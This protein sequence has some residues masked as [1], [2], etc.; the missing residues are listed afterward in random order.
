VSLACRPAGKLAAHAR[1]PDRLIALVAG[2]RPGAKRARPR[3]F[4]KGAM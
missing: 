1:G 4:V 3:I 2:S